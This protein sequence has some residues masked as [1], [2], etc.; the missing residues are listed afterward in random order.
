MDPLTWAMIG[1]GALS[2]GAS[3]LDYRAQ[4][5]AARRQRERDALNA[6]VGSLSNKQSARR[7]PAQ[8]QSVAA[9]VLRG[10]DPLTQ[11]MMQRAQ[12]KPTPQTQDV[13]G[14]QAAV[15]SLN[16]ILENLRNR[17]QQG[18]STGGVGFP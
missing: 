10:L 4:G 1:Q 6:V 2:L 12:R 8:G 9:N 5:R 11:M 16:Q 14:S 15:N 17:S 3:A 18:G 7:A 13:S